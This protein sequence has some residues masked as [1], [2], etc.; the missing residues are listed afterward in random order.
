MLT[1]PFLLCLQECGLLTPPGSAL[2]DQLVTIGHPGADHNQNQLQTTAQ[3]Q[4]LLDPSNNLSEKI[5]ELLEQFEEQG[6]TLPR[7]FLEQ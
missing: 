6:K 2:T 5:D 4:S 3:I 1:K 7:D